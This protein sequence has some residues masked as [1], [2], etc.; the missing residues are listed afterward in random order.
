MS[1]KRLLSTHPDLGFV[2]IFNFQI[3]AQDCGARFF[4]V[5]SQ[6]LTIP[7]ARGSTSI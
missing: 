1:L 7:V 3:T 4:L 2:Q 6:A 5:V